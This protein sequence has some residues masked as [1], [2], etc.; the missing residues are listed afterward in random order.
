M[1]HRWPKHLDHCVYKQL[2]YI[3]MHCWCLLHV[4]MYIPVYTEVYMFQTLCNITKCN[5]SLCVCRF[6]SVLSGL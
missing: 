1:A 6:K 5:P 4:Y 3:C 2:Q